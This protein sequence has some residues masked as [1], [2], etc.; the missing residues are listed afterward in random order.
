M[1]GGGALVDRVADAMSQSRRHIFVLSP[2]FL[3]SDPCM[4][5]LH[6]A[7]YLLMSQGLD[8]AI[9]VILEDLLMT[10]VPGPVTTLLEA[11]GCI[12]W[13][14]NKHGQRIFWDKLERKLLN[15]PKKVIRRLGHKT[16]G[17]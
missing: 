11:T 1:L 17:F 13:T 9:L 10:E 3:A 7:L 14:D 15:R 6:T 12:R 8:T 4:Y 2:N 16:T 5:E